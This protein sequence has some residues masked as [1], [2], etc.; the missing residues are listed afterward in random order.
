M[1]G[2]HFPNVYQNARVIS[3]TFSAGLFAWSVFTGVLVWGAK[4]HG[5]RWAKLLLALQI[6]AFSVSHTVYEFSTFVSLRVMVGN[7]S[8][9]IGGHRR[10]LVFDERIRICAD[11]GFRA[12][13]AATYLTQQPVLRECEA[14]FGKLRQPG[15][16]SL[17]WF[18]SWR[19]FRI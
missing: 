16:G 2:V 15:R 14:Q 3:A 13:E 5:F 9:H 19:T 17:G 12:V 11:G 1:S 6:P 7:T 4:P 10:A 8:H 18:I